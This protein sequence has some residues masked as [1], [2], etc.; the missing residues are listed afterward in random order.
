LT[1][2]E[3][4]RCRFEDSYPDHPVRAT[5]VSPAT[6]QGP[7]IDF[8]LCKGMLPRSVFVKARLTC[9]M[10]TAPYLSSKKKSNSTLLI[11]ASAG[12]MIAWI[13]L[14]L[15]FVKN[16]NDAILPADQEFFLAGG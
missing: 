5:E 7:D 1:R 8:G 9:K 4:L 16:Q 3:I 2:W 12:M 11:V 14:C 6:D 10:G 15:R 13:G